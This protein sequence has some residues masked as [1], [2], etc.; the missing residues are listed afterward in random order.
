[1]FY[2]IVWGASCDTVRVGEGVNEEHAG[3]NAFGYY[4]KVHMSFLAVDKQTLRSAPKRTKLVYDLL[5]QH[6][7][8]FVDSPYIT[9]SAENEKKMLSKVW[10]KDWE[11]IKETGRETG[12]EK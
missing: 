5:K 8:R 11:K 6:Q 4:D 7:I 3:I 10:A 9:A 1:M 12:R 2:L